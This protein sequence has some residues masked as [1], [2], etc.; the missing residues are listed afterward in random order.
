MPPCFPH[1]HHM[2]EFSNMP[3]PILSATCTSR[4]SR[5]LV[6]RP[7]SPVHQRSCHYGQFHNLAEGEL[8]RV[9]GQLICS[10]A[11]RAVP[12]AGPG[13]TTGFI[14]VCCP[15]WVQAL[16]CVLQLVR[17]KV[18]SPTLITWGQLSHL[19]QVARVRGGGYLSLTYA[20][21]W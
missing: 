5:F 2:G 19:L 9:G 11:L 18:S 12:S 4:R 1:H 21:T 17:D 15:R 7:S 13:K 6:F 20:T 8:L 10:H 16:F 14:L 3:Q